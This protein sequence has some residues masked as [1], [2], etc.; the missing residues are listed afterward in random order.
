MFTY[1]Q[2]VELGAVTC[3]VFIP[4][5]TSCCTGTFM[6]LWFQNE[7]DSFQVFPDSRTTVYLIFCTRFFRERELWE[8]PDSSTNTHF[9]HYSL[10]NPL[11]SRISLNCFILQMHI[12]HFNSD[13]YSSISMALDKSDGLAVLGVFIEVRL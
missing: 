5:L 7:L 9:Q 4:D 10:G 11:T 1:S 13:K 6:I 3:N 2:S 8:S 12:V